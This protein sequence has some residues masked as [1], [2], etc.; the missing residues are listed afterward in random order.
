MRQKLVEIVGIVY[1]QTE[2]LGHLEDELQQLE[3]DVI[4]KQE[5]VIKLQQDL[6]TAKEGQLAKFWD[7]VVSSVFG[8]LRPI[9]AWK[10]LAKQEICY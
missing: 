9:L 10:L 8:W 4:D 7:T 1:T 6:I 3:S 5:C 2:I